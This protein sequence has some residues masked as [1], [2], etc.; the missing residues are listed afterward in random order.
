M[1]KRVFATLLSGVLV[2]Y[3]PDAAAAIRRQKQRH[4]VDPKVHPVQFTI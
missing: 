4:Q 3:Y 2:A 1:K